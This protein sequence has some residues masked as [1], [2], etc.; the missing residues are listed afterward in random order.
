[1]KCNTNEA[2]NE[3]PGESA[4]GF[5]I[6]DRHGDPIYAQAKGI[7]IATNIEAEARAIEVALAMSAK[8]GF[9]I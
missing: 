5:C 8:K 9:K 7:G 6:K 1:M 2:S 3:N 4:Y